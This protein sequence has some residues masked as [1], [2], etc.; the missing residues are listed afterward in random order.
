MTKTYF[1]LTAKMLMCLAFATAPRMFEKKSVRT[2]SIAVSRTTGFSRQ[3]KGKAEGNKGE[4]IM[5]RH[6]AMVVIPEAAPMA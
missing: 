2:I 4:S 1:A 5:L 6:R 3:Y